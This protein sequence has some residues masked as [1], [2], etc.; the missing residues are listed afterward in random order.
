M[1]GSRKKKISRVA[2]GVLALVLFYQARPRPGES[3]A[4]G[5]VSARQE[6]PAPTADPLA[7]PV[8][9]EDPTQVDIGRVSYYYNCM[10]CHGDHGQGL[11]EEWR[12]TW[13]VDHRNCWD[14]GCHSGRPSLDN[15][16]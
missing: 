14:R 13:V 15:G 12:Q 11:T 2:L 6:E 16:R 7:I 10:P 1:A 5:A 8:L 4:S 9:P 3:L